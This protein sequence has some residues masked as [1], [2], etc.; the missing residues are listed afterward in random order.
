M[1]G[2]WLSYDPLGPL[3]ALASTQQSYSNNII[4]NVRR[5]NISFKCCLHVNAW[6]IM[7]STLQQRLCCCL[8]TTFN[9]DNVTTQISEYCFSTCLIV[10]KWLYVVFLLI[11]EHFCSF[12]TS[13]PYVPRFILFYRT[14]AIVEFIYICCVLNIQKLIN[15]TFPYDTTLLVHSIS[16][17]PSLKSRGS[18]GDHWCNN[19][20]SQARSSLF[21]QITLM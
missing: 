11:G 16:A 5:S 18:S 17:S 7:P 14:V 19:L 21:R 8:M 9:V 15:L 12:G 10:F 20:A 1:V 4:N 6:M 13:F 3:A 2:F